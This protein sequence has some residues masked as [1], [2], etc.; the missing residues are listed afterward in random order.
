M[1]TYSDVGVGEARLR[2]LLGQPKIAQLDDIALVKE[3]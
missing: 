3:Y 2:E 1:V